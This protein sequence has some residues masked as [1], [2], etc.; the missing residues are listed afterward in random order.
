MRKAFLFVLLLAVLVSCTLDNSTSVLDNSVGFVSFDSSV[1]RGILASIEY[2]SLLDKT[3]TLV[4]T[5]LDGGQ[6]T[7]E[8]Q[9]EDIVLTDSLGPF[10]VGLWRFTITDSE[11]TITGSVDTTIK[12]GNNS[13]PI[14]VRSTSTKGTLSIENCNFLESKIG[15]KVNYVDCYVD[16][17]RV[18]GTD[19]AI[20]PSM[21]EDGDLYTLPTITLQLSGGVHTIRLYFGADNGGTSTETVS[22]RV[23]NG[24]TTRFSIGEHEGNLSVSVSFDVVDAIVE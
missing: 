14:T 11:E 23:V 15:A 12:A 13:I 22:V 20:S 10:S 17:N 1:S 16:D 3:W 5:K 18:N 8:G 7:G 2:P 19:W 4:A 9:Y 6:R 21:T 24:M